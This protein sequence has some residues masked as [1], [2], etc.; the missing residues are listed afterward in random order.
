[1]ANGRA[2]EALTVVRNARRTALRGGEAA[3]LAELLRLQSEVLLSISPANESRAI[4]LLERS[5]R[6]ARPQSALSWE[7][8]SSAA[9]ARIQARRGELD[10]ALRL[11]APIYNRFTE[12]FETHDLKTGRQLLKEIELSQG[13]ITPFHADDGSPDE[14]RDRQPVRLNEDPQSQSSSSPH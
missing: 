8:R 4:R 3:H 2:E 6:I 9:L 12:G 1:M 5:C 10:A 13:S 14:A 11:L 7:L